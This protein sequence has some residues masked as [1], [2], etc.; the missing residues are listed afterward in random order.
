MLVGK[1]GK[2]LL[3][4]L[5]LAIVVLALALVFVYGRTHGTTTPAA[6]PLHEQH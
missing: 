4:Y 5:A 6:T 1:R 3:V 2:P